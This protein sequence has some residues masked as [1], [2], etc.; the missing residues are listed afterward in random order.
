ES[1]CPWHPWC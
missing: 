1:E